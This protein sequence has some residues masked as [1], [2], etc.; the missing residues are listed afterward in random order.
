MYLIAQHLRCRTHIVFLCLV[1]QVVVLKCYPISMD[2]RNIVLFSVKVTF[3]FVSSSF[4]GLTRLILISQVWI[5]HLVLHVLRAGPTLMESILNDL[6]LS[7][8]EPKRN[9]VK[10]TGKIDYV[11][12]PISLHTNAYNIMYSISDMHPLWPSLIS[13]SQ[14]ILKSGL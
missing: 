12:Y 6:K 13:T 2:N 10:Y 1:P 4:T 3:S 14:N 8:W 11:L 9:A 7:S 5:E